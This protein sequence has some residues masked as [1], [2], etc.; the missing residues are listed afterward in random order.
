M[1]ERPNQI[2]PVTTQVSIFRRVGRYRFALG[3]RRAARQ[4]SS[5]FIPPLLIFQCIV[6]AEEMV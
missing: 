5:V 2:I 3:A 1:K 6:D 4:I